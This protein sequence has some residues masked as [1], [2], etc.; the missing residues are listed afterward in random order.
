[1]TDKLSADQFDKVTKAVDIIESHED[2]RIITDDPIAWISIFVQYILPIV[3]KQALHFG[4]F[5]TIIIGDSEHTTALAAAP[6]LTQLKALGINAA[7]IYQI[8]N[9]KPARH[10]NDY[11][12]IFASA[13]DASR[14]LETAMSTVFGLIVVFD[15][16]QNSIFQTTAASEIYSAMIR[17]PFIY[18][19]RGEIGLTVDNFAMLDAA[20]FLYWS[21]SP[22]PPTP[23]PGS[24]S[25]NFRERKFE[26]AR[27]IGAPEDHAVS[28]QMRLSILGLLKQIEQLCVDNL[29][30]AALSRAVESLKDTLSYEAASI[31]L[32]KL[33]IDSRMIGSIAAFYGRPDAG[34]DLNLTVLID[35]LNA[36]I[37][38]L[39]GQFAALKEIEAGRLGLAVAVSDNP[40]EL[41]VPVSQMVE[42]VSAI[43]VVGQSVLD[44]LTEG[45]PEIASL[46]EQIDD[47][48]TAPDVRATAIRARGSIIQQQLVTV[49]NLGTAAL[50]KVAKT[51]GDGA[52]DGLREASA[53][54]IKGTLLGAAAELALALGQPMMAL[55]IVAQ[56]FKPLA[57]AISNKIKADSE[58]QE[59]EED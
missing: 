37:Q 56:S 36:G 15:A 34:R 52:L 7:S 26:A 5:R 40:N 3:R 1:M 24:Y 2:L 4:P 47:P 8:V 45:N 46:S 10:I 31:P 58:E 23:I 28:E 16:G 55:S 21:A 22:L 35:A 18:V 30:D 51:T 59:G 41:L 11:D 43:D 27:T 9:S 49:W 44:A 19:S 32:G 53:G 54:I 48:L 14:I 20:E 38:D 33:Q 39:A 6:A 50:S 12:V 25:I 57:K 13:Q 17:L 29:A 42:A